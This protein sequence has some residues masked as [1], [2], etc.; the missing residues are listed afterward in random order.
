MDGPTDEQIHRQTETNRQKDEGRYGPYQ[1]DDTDGQ[2]KMRLHETRPDIA[3]VGLYLRSLDHL[4]RSSEV[5]VV[6]I[7]FVGVNVVIAILSICIPKSPKP[8]T[9]RENQ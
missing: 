4:A 8:V 5:V 6:V 3:Q 1:R 9:E 7:A 2:S